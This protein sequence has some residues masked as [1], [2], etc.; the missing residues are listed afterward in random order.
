MGKVLYHLHKDDGLAFLELTLADQV[1][2]P[3]RA[4][5][6]LDTVEQDAFEFGEHC[7]R[8]H[9]ALGRDA[10]ALAHIIGIGDHVFPAHHDRRADL[11]GRGQRSI[12]DA[13]LLPELGR[14]DPDA[15]QRVWAFVAFNPVINPAWVPALPVA[16]T[17]WSITRPR[18]LAWPS[19]SK[20]QLTYPKAPVALEPPP[21]ML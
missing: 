5:G 14:M 13:F 15:K 10:V 16:W 17:R 1:D 6:L 8:L 18:S 20:A 4:L 2:Q 12:V 21:G 19:S 11:G 7:D 9:P 3:R